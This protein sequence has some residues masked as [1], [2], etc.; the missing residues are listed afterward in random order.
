[1]PRELNLSP[2][3]VEQILAAHDVRDPLLH[4]VDRGGELIRPVPLAIAD[5]EVPALQM[6]ALL[7][8]SEPQIDEALDRRLQA[9]AQRHARTVV[10]PARAARAGIRELGIDAARRWSRRLRR[11]DVAARARARVD[12][13][14]RAKTLERARVDLAALALPRHPPGPAKAEPRQILEDRGVVGRPAALP[15][16][17]LDPQQHARAEIPHVHGVQ[18]VTEVQEPGWRRREPG[19]HYAHY[20]KGCPTLARVGV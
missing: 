17:V 12:E 11:G 6:G 8:R 7:L 18:H 15:I 5:D 20:A 4:V 10:Q 9:H 2:R 19:Y 13:P 3:G 14:L 1:Q 16:V